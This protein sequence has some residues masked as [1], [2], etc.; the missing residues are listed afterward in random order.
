MQRG[1]EKKTNAMEAVIPVLKTAARPD[2]EARRKH[3][4]GPREADGRNPHAP[5]KR[6]GSRPH[7]KRANDKKRE[8]AA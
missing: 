8:G 1:A 5:A 4:G 7:W 6:N 3:G 2:H